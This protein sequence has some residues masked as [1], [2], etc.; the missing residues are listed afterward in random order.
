M[1]LHASLIKS[2]AQGTV[3]LPRQHARRPLLGS[4]KSV[5]SIKDLVPFFS[6]IS[7]FSYEGVYSSVTIGA[8]GMAAGGM[9]DWEAV[10]RTLMEEMF[11]GR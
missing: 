5:E 6:H 3:F 4:I 9:V 1:S 7:L 10:E 2:P 11:D 8:S